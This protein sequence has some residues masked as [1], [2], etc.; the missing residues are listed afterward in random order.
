ML[1]GFGGADFGR[2]RRLPVLAGARADR[3]HDQEERESYQE[4]D[5]PARDEAHNSMGPC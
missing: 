1:A 4:I 2:R 5:S 3:R